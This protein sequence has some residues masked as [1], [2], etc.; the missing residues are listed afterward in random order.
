[1]VGLKDRGFGVTIM[2]PA[3]PW[4]VTT[5][6][7]PCSPLPSPLRLEFML[8]LFLPACEREWLSLLLL[9]RPLREL[10]VVESISAEVDAAPR[11]SGTS[12]PKASQKSDSGFRIRSRFKMVPC[13]AYRT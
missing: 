13:F 10:L 7:W 11:Q 3:G 1:M 9:P 2:G 8:R 5:G 12:Q 6:R 4:I